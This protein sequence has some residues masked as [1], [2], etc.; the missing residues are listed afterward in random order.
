MRLKNVRLLPLPK[1]INLAV[2]AALLR[3]N[4]GYVM[5]LLSDMVPFSSFWLNGKTAGQIQP[6]DIPEW[7]GGVPESEARKIV[8]Y[9]KTGGL[10]RRLTALYKCA[11]ILARLHGNGLVYGD[12]SPLNA[13]ISE[14]HYR[15]E[16]W[17]IDADNLRFEI[18]SGG[19]GVYTPQY[20]APEL[21]N[22]RDGGRPVSDCHAFAVMAFYMLTM[23]HPFIGDYVTRGGEMD[24]A[25]DS[26]EDESLDEKAYS[27]EIPWIED[28]K[29]DLNRLEVGGLRGLLTIT[30]ELHNLFQK[31]LGDGR[32]SP[33][34]RPAIYHW[35]IALAEAADRTI[36][37]AS[38]RM[39]WYVDIGAETCPYCGSIKP[40]IL[41][42][43]AYH[44]IGNR[45]LDSPCQEFAHEIPDSGISLKIPERLFKSFSM[46][47]SDNSILE[48]K[49]TGQHLLISKSEACDI[50]IWIAQPGENDDKF[51]NLVSKLRLPFSAL[52][53]GFWVYADG[54]EPRLISCS[55]SGGGK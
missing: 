10:R 9:Y 32:T 4:A 45:N 2:P 37:C 50:D 30:P 53:T 28:E 54:D 41:F 20:G 44:W 12:I 25:D 22:G 14:D 39:S 15:T 46:T 31:T 38:C 36:L 52:E 16:V 24:W 21:V 18:A 33:W 47:G 5:Q 8:H 35:P 51:K 6:T 48:L 17:L 29:D 1:G 27:G 42:C 7:L 55:A 3:D 11:A 43:R 13:Y 23:V 26:A 19:S 40:S 34:K 49:F